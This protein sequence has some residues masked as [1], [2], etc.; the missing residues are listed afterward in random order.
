LLILVS[1]PQEYMQHKVHIDRTVSDGAVAVFLPMTEGTY[2]IGQESIR[3][4]YCAMNALHF[5]SRNTGHPMV[6][7]FDTRDFSFW[8]DETLGYIS[9]LLSHSFTA[10]GNWNPILRT[11]N[12][13]DQGQWRTALAAAEIVHGKGVFRVCQVSL[14]GRIRTNPP[15]GLFA[16]RLFKSMA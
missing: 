16:E 8:F 13:D 14:G 4:R 12:V 3:V 7:D 6:A 2:I 9:P 11:G 10:I 1:D 15:A 5:V